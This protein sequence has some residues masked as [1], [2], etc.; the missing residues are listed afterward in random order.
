MARCDCGFD[1]RQMRCPNGCHGSA[2]RARQ[3]SLGPSHA[4]TVTNE[5]IA[6]AL[7][8]KGTVKGAARD[9]G[10]DPQT[11]RDRAAAD[12]ALR[13]ELAARDRSKSRHSIFVDMVGWD[14][15]GWRVI[16]EGA[17]APNGNSRWLAKHHCGG[18]GLLRGSA[19]RKLP[20]RFCST[21]RPVRR[22][23]DP[24]G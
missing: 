13:S 2:S 15:D 12:E 9:L 10:I 7:S 1:P 23:G 22:S 14:R 11:I 16:G 5:Q 6:Q 3:R 4:R 24:R 18:T 21:C 20:P 8:L 19:L 17:P